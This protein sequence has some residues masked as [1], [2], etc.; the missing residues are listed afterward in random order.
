VVASD[1]GRGLKQPKEKKKKKKT[2]PTTTTRGVSRSL[3][4]MRKGQG[5]KKMVD[6]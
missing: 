1:R 6:L 3:S 4:F 2:N 5:N